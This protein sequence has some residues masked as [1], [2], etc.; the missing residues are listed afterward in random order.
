[1]KL[2]K[3]LNNISNLDEFLIEL[4]EQYNVLINSLDSIN[5]ELL[6]TNPLLI[7][8]RQRLRKEMKETKS[9]I[10]DVSSKIKVLE[11]EI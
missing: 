8:K 4:K 5:Q 1:M 11:S 6:N 7:A 10:V 3:N 9:K 2:K